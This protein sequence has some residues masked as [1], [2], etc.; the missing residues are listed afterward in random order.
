MG[1][2]E[3]KSIID[4]L[5]GSPLPKVETKLKKIRDELSEKLWEAAY[6]RNFF[7]LSM[8]LVERI[9]TWKQ[10]LETIGL[11]RGEKDKNLA[12]AK[13]RA[14]RQLTAIDNHQESV[15][16]NNKFRCYLKEIPEEVTGHFKVIV[17]SMKKNLKNFND[18]QNS[19]GVL[20]FLKLD[21]TFDNKTNIKS[22]F[23]AFFDALNAENDHNWKKEFKVTGIITDPKDEKELYSQVP[24]TD[25]HHTS[26][27]A[28]A[29]ASVI[30]LTKKGCYLNIWFQ[31]GVAK[32]LH[33]RYGQG[34]FF[35]SDFVHAGGR[36]A[37]NEPKEEKF[38][39]LHFYHETASQKAPKDGFNY[40]DIDRKTRYKDFFLIG[41]FGEY[42]ED[43]TN[44]VFLHDEK[45]NNKK[46]KW[47][48]N[49][50]PNGKNNKKSKLQN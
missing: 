16:K 41:K 28:L 44:F 22:A 26:T 9:P 33:V 40:W 48:N 29:W 37:P 50:K 45:D 23:K 34:F 5:K 39:R 10:I 27:G 13:N 21:E 19:N 7:K 14:S 35:R 1:D 30:P 42:A 24:H 15:W 38:Y 17:D 20:K 43:N 18:I 8:N 6:L 32:V 25:Y 46:R 12:N 2:E 31:P 36:I 49:K 4:L 3:G 47:K 11:D